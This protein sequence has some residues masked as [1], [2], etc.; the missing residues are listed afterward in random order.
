MFDQDQVLFAFGRLLEANPGVFLVL[1]G[2]RLGL[3]WHGASSK[4]GYIISPGSTFD[5]RHLRPMPTSW[6]LSYFLAWRLDLDT[7]W[8]ELGIR[9]FNLLHMPFREIP[10]ITTKPWIRDYRLS[11]EAIGRRIFLFFRGSI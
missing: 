7:R 9:A 10:P 11:A 1:G 8:L 6:F 3:G 4:E 5:V 2:V